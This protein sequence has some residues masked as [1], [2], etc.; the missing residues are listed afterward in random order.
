MADEIPPVTTADAES[1]VPATAPEPG[2]PPQA[3]TGRATTAPR[4]TRAGRFW[5]TL[6][7]TVLVVVLLIIF[8][9]ENSQRVTVHFLGAEGSISAALALLIAAVAG[10]IIM[11]LVGTIR[12]A[13]LRGEV[14]RHERRR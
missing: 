10:A 7:F 9:A 4:S 6:G 1:T 13:Q 8:V 12:I 11:L 14:K 2:F 5:V 3:D